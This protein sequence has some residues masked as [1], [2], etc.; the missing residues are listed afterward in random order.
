[1]MQVRP[2]WI[3]QR[4][5]K[6]GEAEVRKTRSAVEEVFLYSGRYSLDI[7]RTTIYAQSDSLDVQ[8]GRK[9]AKSGV[10][11]HSP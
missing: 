8:K 3:L 10:G 1:M 9:F 2:I 7:T 4:V 11:V 5:E 6:G